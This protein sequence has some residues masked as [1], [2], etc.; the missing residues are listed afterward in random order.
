MQI[1][2]QHLENF[3]TLFT[4]EVELQATIIQELNRQRYITNESKKFHLNKQIKMLKE[5]YAKKMVKSWIKNK[6]TDLVYDIKRF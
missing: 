5:A 6:R 4:K 3:Y 1:Q 2:I